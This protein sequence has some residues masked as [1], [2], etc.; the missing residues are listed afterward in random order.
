MTPFLVALSSWRRIM[1][2]ACWI[3]LL[4]ATALIAGPAGSVARADGVVVQFG[5]LKSKSPADWK[6]EEVPENAQRLGRIHQFKLPKKGDDKDDAELLV[7]YFKGGGGDVKA[8][9]DRWKGM[10]DPPEGKKIDDVAK[11]T[12]TKVGD[13]PV[14][15][16]EVEGTYKFKKAP[17]DPKA[18]VTLKPNYKMVNIIFDCPKGPY[19]VRMVGPAKT[20][21]AYKKGFDEWVKA[22]K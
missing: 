2:Y 9:I 16:F 10:F 12:E 8:N 7:F 5:D 6:E 22:F 21:D 13:S 11:T 19:Y 15:Y 3:M 20:I 4:G 1:K 17:F 14:T 18:E